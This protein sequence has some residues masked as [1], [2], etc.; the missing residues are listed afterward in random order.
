MHD[1]S[2]PDLKM[3]IAHTIRFSF[4]LLSVFAFSPVFAFA[5]EPGELHV[6]PTGDVSVKMVNVIQVAGNNLFARVSWGNSSIRL[7]VLLKDAT[8][9]TRKFGGTAAIKDIKEDHFLT[10]EGRLVDGNGNLLIDAK[11]V[12]DQSLT[13][14]EKTVEGTV[15]A[16]NRTSNMLSA[17]VKGLGA[18]K[19]AL[20]AST[21][22]RKG[23]RMIETGELAA[24]DRIL[25]ASGTY[26]FAAK[27][28]T[29]HSL[30]IY[31]DKKMF[32]PRSFEGV[33]GSISGTSLPATVSLASA[34]KTYTVY[35][36]ATT[37]LA[38]KTG[39]SIS[40]GRMAAGDRVT[41]KGKIREMNFSE[42]DASSVKDFTF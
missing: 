24:G 11:K 34:G 18:I 12:V 40:L 15:T 31:Q 6:L 3:K 8:V 20:S 19:L 4:A 41:V 9:V 14:E 10:V 17:S 26:D 21:P 38:S 1:L 23:A 33:I 29:V 37:T 7:T 5:A 30:E 16:V 2:A 35:L 25:S 13:T 39:T 22:V 42:V 32:Q 27:T 36:T 28:L